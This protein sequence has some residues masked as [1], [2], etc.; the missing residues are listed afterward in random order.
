MTSISKTTIDFLKALK[1]NNNRDW[2][3]EHKTEFQQEQK[4]AKGFYNAVMEKLKQHDEIESVKIFR[5]YRDVR[6]SPDKTP[7]KP[8]FAG[9]FV[10]ATNKLRGGYYLR[11]RPGES[12]LAGGFWEPNKEDL[13]RI[14]KEFEMD[15][16]EIREIISNPTFVTYFE[17]LEGDA[18]K[19]AP[20]GFDKEHPNMDLIRMKQFI[21]TRKFT[22]DEVLAPNFLQEVNESYKAMRPYFNYMSDVLTT[23]LNGVSI[24]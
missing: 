11:I 6:F 1:E 20:R 2:F 3:T 7:Y 8:H 21:V 19:T 23:D 12:F 16:S 4:K 17:K 9:N 24:L 10:R 13:L 15:A 5:I 22:D 18:L 14:R